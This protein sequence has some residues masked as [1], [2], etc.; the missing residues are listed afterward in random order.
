MNYYKNK[1][2][3]WDCDRNQAP[4][5]THM[6]VGRSDDYS[7]KRQCR[8]IRSFMN[9]SRREELIL[10]VSAVNEYTKSKAKIN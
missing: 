1:D 2:K 5:K 8:R 3:I 10:L 4:L 6:S 7:F 9:N